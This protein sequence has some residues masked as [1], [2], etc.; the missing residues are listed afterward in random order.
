MERLKINEPAIDFITTDYLNNEIRLSDYKEKKVLLTFFRGA[1]CPFCNM[2]V[3]QLIKQ[4]PEFQKQGISII[5]L[6]GSTK[7]EI[8]N[9]AGKQNAPFP[10]IADPE[11]KIYKKYKIEESQMGMLKVMRNPARVFKMMFSGFFNLN[12]VKDRPIVPADFLIDENQIIHKTYYGEDFSDHISISEVLN[13][14]QNAQ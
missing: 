14:K 13:W 7:E 2:R 5:A 6:F 3:N 4:Y 12:A 8:Q 11:F 10:I 1:S 9:Y